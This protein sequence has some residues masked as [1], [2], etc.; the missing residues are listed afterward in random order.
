MARNDDEYLDNSRNIYGI[1]DM[2][3]A[4]DKFNSGAAEFPRLFCRAMNIPDN[5]Y[6][7]YSYNEKTHD[8][9]DGG[10]F[11]KFAN[12]LAWQYRTEYSIEKISKRLYYWN[13][14]GFLFFVFV[15]TTTI[16]ITIFVYH[17][18][19]RIRSMY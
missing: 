18:C 12:R 19:Y 11:G 15:L 8:E 2:P 9:R 16:L 13:V 10:T 1:E 3:K 17:F 6:M 7:Y 14:F 4:L 5:V